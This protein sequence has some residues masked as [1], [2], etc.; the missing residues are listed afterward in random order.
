MAATS[1]RR[2]GTWFDAFKCEVVAET[3]VPGVK[4]GEVSHDLLLHPKR[5]DGLTGRT[6][7]CDARCGWRL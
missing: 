2:E 5:T 3:L 4:V 7:A 6:S 1:K